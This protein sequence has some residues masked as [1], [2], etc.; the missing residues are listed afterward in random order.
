MAR[1]QST[2]HAIGNADVEPIWSGE[3]SRARQYP[4]RYGL[5]S[6]DMS[7]G[8]SARMSARA[9]PVKEVCCNHGTVSTHYSYGLYGYGQDTVLYSMS[10][11]MSLGHEYIG[12]NY[13]VSAHFYKHVSRHVGMAGTTQGG[14]LLAPARRTKT[15]SRASCRHL[16]ISYYN[17][18]VS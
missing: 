1:Y 13:T 10:I 4:P 14:T 6:I 17:I 11:D 18:Q 8:M 9:A 3:G 7:L 12:H 16:H 5:M 15:E 2:R